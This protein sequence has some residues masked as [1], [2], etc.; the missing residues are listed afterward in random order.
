MSG[1]ILVVVLV[2]MSIIAIWV[3][4]GWNDESLCASRVGEDYLQHQL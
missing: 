3:W 1:I 4:S 2:V